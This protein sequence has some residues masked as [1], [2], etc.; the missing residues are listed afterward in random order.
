MN[1]APILIVDDDSDDREFLQDAWK[2]LEFQNPLIFFDNGEDA[3]D[4][5][6]SE[7]P[8][9]FLILCDVNIHKMDGFE[10]KEKIRENSSV[11]YKSIPFIFWSSTVSAVQ[12][13]KAYD[14]GVNG[15]FVKE[16]SF[17]E[18]KQSLI[19]MV[20]YWLKSKVP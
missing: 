18:I 7:K 17:D 12:I 3:L 14:L 5:L 4:Y 11:N 6:K 13:Q 20:E 9:P 10:L 2:D 1:N 15:F 16:T 8:K 19:S